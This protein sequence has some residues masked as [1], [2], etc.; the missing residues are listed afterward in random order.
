L[1]RGPQASWRLWCLPKRWLWKACPLLLPRWWGGVGRAQSPIVPEVRRVVWPK[2]DEWCGP[3]C[4]FSKE[5]YRE[6]LS[7]LDFRR[8]CRRSR[9]EVGEDRC[10]QQGGVAEGRRAMWP[11][12]N[13]SRKPYRECL[14]R[15]DFRRR[16]RRS[17]TKVVCREGERRWGA[18]EAKDGG[19]TVAS[20]MW[21][22]QQQHKIGRKARKNSQKQSTETRI[23]EFIEQTCP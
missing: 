21:T 19:V 12:C 11:K 5:P 9:E 17:R 1:A 7:R 14:S 23:R 8:R 15:L 2:A 18:V 20:K 6:G 3:K 10:P 16:C 22:Q 4:N 13:F